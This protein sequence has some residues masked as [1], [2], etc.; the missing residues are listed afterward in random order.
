MP[1][2]H[3]LQ[4][5]VNQYH[6]DSKVSALQGCIKDLDT[7]FDYL[8]VDFAHL[9]DPNDP[10]S[11][12]LRFTD[13]DATR[14]KVIDGF[15][16]I[17][18]RTQPDDFVLIQF[19]GH[20]SQSVSAKE[21]WDHPSTAKYDEGFLLHDSRLPDGYDLAD[22][23]IAQL[24]SAFPAGAEIVFIADCCHAGTITR[25]GEGTNVRARFHEARKGE[26]RPFNSY[27]GYDSKDLFPQIPESD[28]I[29]I[30][31]CSGKE[32]AFEEEQGI[33]TQALIAQLRDEKGHVSYAKLFERV[34]TKVNQV[35]TAQTPQFDIQG[36]FNAH[37]FFL[38][39]AEDEADSYQVI[40]DHDTNEWK[41]MAGAVHGLADDMQLKVAIR[42]ADKPEAPAKIA[43][44]KSVRMAHC[45]LEGF[46]ADDFEIPRLAKIINVLQPTLK[47]DLV[48]DPNLCDQVKAHSLQSPAHLFSTGFFVDAKYC[49]KLSS[50]TV[51][52]GSTQF[53]AEVYLNE[54]EKII[55]RIFVLNDWQ[56]FCKEIEQTFKIVE[57][58]ERLLAVSSTSPDLDGRFD[59]YIDVDN[60]KHREDAFNVPVVEDARQKTI[61]KDF[62]ILAQNNNELP[63]YFTLLQFNRNYS[64]FAFSQNEEVKANE[65]SKIRENKFLI[66]DSSHESKLVF[67]LIVSRKALDIAHLEQKLILNL[68]TIHRGTKDTEPY[69]EINNTMV[70]DPE[71]WQTADKT[72]MVVRQK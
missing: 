19:S 45:V 27:F 51:E 58:W 67:K 5:G 20:G 54:P 40:R 48:G 37:R 23:E 21:L 30:T 26:P 31:A 34:R 57:K 41:M 44:I 7:L 55:H 56:L 42:P 33:F 1:K 18:K 36:N 17:A 65:V 53:H 59:W 11:E 39:K 71:A 46:D 12:P 68:G 8:K 66:G 24:L 43:S 64:I 3:L 69:E 28:H 49:C 15:H 25:E 13:G 22:K 6:P 50:N 60:A 35:E 63:V 62:K 10:T 2:L 29:A 4:V 16:Q 70:T 9:F 61:P 52:P 14:E 47:F 32:K 38:S 72:V